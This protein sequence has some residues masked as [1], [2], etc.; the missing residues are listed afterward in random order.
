MQP[1][2]TIEIRRLC[3]LIGTT[4]FSQLHEKYSQIHIT[5]IQHFRYTSC[6]VSFQVIFRICKNQLYLIVCLILI[7]LMLRNDFNDKDRDFNQ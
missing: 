7:L 5:D 1:I 2:Y 4:R 6:T 3:L